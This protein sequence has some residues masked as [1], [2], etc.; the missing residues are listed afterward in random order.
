MQNVREFSQC[1]RKLL[2]VFSLYTSTK[3][4]LDLAL[5]TSG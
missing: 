3:E 2:R 5:Y 4:I 1:P